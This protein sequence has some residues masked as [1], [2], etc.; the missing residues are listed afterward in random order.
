[1]FLYLFNGPDNTLRIYTH[2]LQSIAISFSLSALK[3]F[4]GKKEERTR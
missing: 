2:T 4:F 1:M 3:D